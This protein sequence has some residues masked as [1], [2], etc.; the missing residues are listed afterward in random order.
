[1]RVLLA[2]AVIIAC[3]P[4]ID[5][6]TTFCVRAGDRVLF[7]RN[8]D[9]ETGDGLVLVNP[10][11]LRKTGLLTGGPSWVA[12]YGSVTFN[13]FGRGFPMGGINEAGVV[14]E[15]MWLDA[16]RYPAA[17][18]RA[19]LEVLEWIQYQ[20]DTAGSVA[21]VV[22]SDSRVRIQ[23]RVPLHYLVSDRTGAAATIE[24]LDGSMVTHSGETLPVAV[25][26]NETY[27]TSKA[28][29]EARRGRVPGGDGSNPRFARAASALPSI[30]SAG[31]ASVARAFDVLEDVSQRV[32][33]WSIVYDVTRA[34]VH[35]RTDRRSAIRMLGLASLDFSCGAVPLAV[36]IHASG[37][38][39]ARASLAPLT[40]TANRD[41]LRRSMN[42]T[43]FTRAEPEA[44]VAARS[45]NG[46]SG[47]C[48]AGT[49]AAR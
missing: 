21:D 5:A 36:D 19:P 47:T 3:Q 20:L 17:D 2:A 13:Q 43:S 37:D 26:A 29:A 46:Y 49:A 42:A 14:V 24:F 41:F 7:G 45:A 12:R 31:D 11:G 39:D 4:V 16:T 23:D 44:V 22:A 38:T 1:M 28:F 40:E 15:Q 32:T 25:L 30:A 10:A 18:A 48:G 33:R 6:C 34:E 8:Y 9:F 27:A 35:W